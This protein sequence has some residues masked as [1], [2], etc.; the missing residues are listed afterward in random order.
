MTAEEILGLLNDKPVGRAVAGVSADELVVSGDV[1]A[2]S[3]VARPGKP[4][5]E[6]ALE[7]DS[8]SL[9]R[10]AEVFEE[11]P[12]IKKMFD[13]LVPEGGDKK[14]AK[15]VKAA[16]KLATADFHAAAFEPDPKLADACKNPRLSQY[17]RQLMETPEFAQ[18]HRETQLDETASEIAAAAYAEQWVQLV[19]TEA[20][21]DE[22]K[23]DMQALRS[24]GAA[25]ES[26][27]SEVSDLRGAQ[28]ALGMGSG[29][30][31]AS[32]V[33][34]KELAGVFKRVKSSRVLKRI[35]E[36]AGRYRRFAQA[37][38]RKKVLH[39][40]DDVVGVVLDG[41]LGRLLPQELAAL[42]DPDLELD[43]MR[44]LVERQSMC[45]DYRGVESQARGPIVVVV[46]ESGSMSGEPICTAKAMALALAWIARHQKRYCCLVGFSGGT[47]GNWLVIPPGKDD[48]T[49]LMRW[50]EHFFSGGTDLDVPLEILPTKWEELGCPRGKTDIVM[51]T[52]A[53][54]QIPTELRD[55]FLAFKARE[56]VKLITL[57]LNREPGDM[58][59]VSDR[60]HCVQSLSLDEAGVAEA[61]GV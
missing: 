18:L 43:A 2:G 22:F 42:A 48:P 14:A 60:I 38:Q 16:A 26:A 52:D 3:P 32:G 31:G 34:A 11:S 29:G 50:L 49:A 20:P 10:G 5:S 35:C 15:A 6:T 44:R 51:I 45:R 17:M 36:L 28:S 23:S 55:S 9:R 57:V 19:Q 1:Q 40:Q 47:E 21:A 61:L 12:R 24:A 37:Q 58:T 46:D 4:A 27:A 59:Q 8:W 53:I 13:A 41:D 33:S 54:L 30:D 56:K 39:G 25:L 7:L